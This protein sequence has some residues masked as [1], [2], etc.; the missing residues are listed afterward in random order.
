MSTQPNVA[1][2]G[3]QRID[4]LRATTTEPDP[5]PAGS[6]KTVVAGHDSAPTEYTPVEPP[7]NGGYG[8]VCVAACFMINGHT[9]GLNSS[10]G[11]FLSYYLDNDYYPGVSALNFA[12]VGG[13][14]ISQALLVSP[15]ATTTTRLYGTRVTLL[16][17]VFFETLALIGASFAHEIWQLFLS[18]GVCFGVGMGFLF[19]GSVGVVPQWFTTKRSLANGVATAGSGIGGLMYS[20]ATDAMIQSLGIGWAFRILGILAFT[21]NTK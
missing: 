19:I 16:I 17:G 15:L 5:S 7:P 1:R 4:P 21:V 12:F 8:W 2:G 13:L 10:Y 6:E 20:L 3:D 18:Q 9:W 11:V 14:S